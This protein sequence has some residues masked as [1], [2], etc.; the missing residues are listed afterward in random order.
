MK[1]VDWLI[2]I[3]LGVLWGGSFLFNAILLREIGP[4]TISLGRV[5]VAALGC[6]F[7]LFAT[8]V[9]LPSDWRIY[10][11][12]TLL[13]VLNFAIPFALFPLAQFHV[14]VGVAGIVNAVTPIMVVI[15]S[16]FWPCGEKAS[17]MKSIGVAIAFAGVA[18][19]ALPAVQKGGGSELWAIGMIMFATF[20]YGVSMN[21][22]RSFNHV[23]PS[24]IATIA[25]TGATVV[26][27]PVA[28]LAEGMPSIQ[29]AESWGA[30]L[31]IGL[32][33][34]CFTFLVVYRILERVGATNM[35]SA[36]FIAPISA[37]VL[38]FVVLGEQI[39]PIHFMGMFTIFIG[40]LALDGRLFKL[41]RIEKPAA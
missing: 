12:L 19:I 36:T 6:W 40:I 29:T 4:L 26:L 32:V 30:L 24:L 9:A 18:L 17:R 14:N 38:G 27:T 2:I 28:L 41:L 23:N 25:L 31:Y 33:A 1:I 5:G 16:H 39:Q 10:A 13:G 7:Y 35:S 22:T 21:Y 20:L 3:G 37:I 15:V 11:G 34:T 8:K